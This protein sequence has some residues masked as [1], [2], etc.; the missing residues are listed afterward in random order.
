[1][2][3]GL[4]SKMTSPAGGVNASHCFFLRAERIEEDGQKQ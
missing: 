4:S 2:R 3:A 1:M